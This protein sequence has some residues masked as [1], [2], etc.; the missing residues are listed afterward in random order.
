LYFCVPFGHVFCRF[1]PLRGCNTKIWLAKYNFCIFY[2][3]TQLGNPCVVLQ[4][5]RRIIG[6]KFDD[7]VFL[8]TVRPYFFPFCT[9]KRTLHQNMACKVQYLYYFIYPHTQAIY[10]WSYGTSNASLASKL[11]ILY[12][13]PS[14]G[15]L[16]TPV[17]GVNTKIWL[18][19]YNFCIVLFTHPLRQ[20]I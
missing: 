5:S 17:R 6:F 8:T 14:F 13:C 15:H 7:F 3:P 16:F 20:S 19:T 11:T 1:L 18:Q 9:I 12:F 2:L 4:Y 10:L